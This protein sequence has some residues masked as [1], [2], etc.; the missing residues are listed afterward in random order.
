MLGAY[1]LSTQ[2]LHS[3]I[4]LGLKW[5]TVANTPAYYIMELITAIKL[6]STISW[7]QCYKTFYDRYKLDCL[8]LA[9]LSSF[10]N[11]L[12]ARPGAYPRVQN[13]KVSSI[14]VGSCFTNKYQTRL[15]RLSRDKHSGLLRTFVNY[16]RK[17]FYNIGPWSDN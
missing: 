5:L 10:V 16:V 1:H 11:C 15:E 14:G 17:K 12:W 4:R 2:A 13:L 9:S 3:I 7:G 8:S 6:C